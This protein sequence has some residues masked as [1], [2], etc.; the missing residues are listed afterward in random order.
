MTHKELLKELEQLNYP[1]LSKTLKELKLI[2]SVKLVKNSAHIVLQCSSSESFE[3]LRNF[4]FET[5]K[6]RFSSLEI[7]QKE[8]AK[9]DKNYGSTHAPNNRAPYAKKVIAITS[10]KGGVG[11]STVSVNIA[12]TLAQMNYRVGLLDADVYGPNIPRLTQTDMERLQWND[13]N[14][15]IP[16]ENFGIKI[17]SVA[18]TTPAQD[19]PLVWRSSVAVSAL[20]Q[21][22]EDVA[23]GELDFLVID[24]PPGT[25]DVQLTIAQELPISAAVLVTT[26]QLISTDDVSRAVKM[27]QDINVPIA[28]L[29]ENMSYFIAPDTNTRYDIFG[30]GGGEKIAKKY[31]IT[32]LG[33]VPLEMAIREN[34]DLGNP[35]AAVGSDAQ[36]EYYKVIT[37]G[38]LK[39]LN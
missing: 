5:Y 10:G 18:L 39:R 24:M 15:I 8:I 20:I 9:K 26:P 3:T 4:L 23:W 1:G 30:T 22:L 25:G 16:S 13:E 37:E 11:K 35:I 21:F 29:V 19:T 34:S 17:M 27:F 7:S 36:K 6:E 31:D 32:L 12:V 33:Q 2:T 14:K 38:V 28:G